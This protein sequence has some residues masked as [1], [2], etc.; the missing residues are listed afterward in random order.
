M[1]RARLALA[2]FASLAALTAACNIGP[3]PLPPGAEVTADFD[4]SATGGSSAVDTGDA[5]RTPSPIAD[6]APPTADA[7]VALFDGGDA[8]D[9]GT[10]L[11]AAADSGAMTND[12]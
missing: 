10:P 6:A 7:G 5:G 11:D 9:S 3:Q 12:F 1:T 8:G 4:A 2:V